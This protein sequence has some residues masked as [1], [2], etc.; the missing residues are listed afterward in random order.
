MRSFEEIRAELEK[1]IGI[2]DPE[3]LLRCA[4]E[5]DAIGTPQ[6]DAEASLARGTAYRLRGDYTEAVNHSYRALALFEE[7]GNST[8]VAAATNN[9]GIVQ[10]HTGNYSAAL[11]HFHRVLALYEKVGSRSGMANATSNIG[12]VYQRTGDYAVALEYFHR[13]LALHEELDNRAGVASAN[14]NI[15]L[16]HYNI[17]DYPAALEHYHLALALREKIGDRDGEAVAISNIG[18]VH[19][20]TGNYPSALE[21]HHRALELYEMIGNRSGVAA[22]INDIGNVH[23]HTGNYSAALE[24]YHRA[25]SIHQET[26]NRANEAI[27][28]GNIGLVHASIGDYPSAI[29]DYRRALDLYEEMGDRAGRARAA[30]SIVGTYLL[31]D[32][33][34]DA[35]AGLAAMDEMQIDEPDVRIVREHIRASILESGDDLN[36]AAATLQR[37][38]TEALEHGLRAEA[39]ESHKRL[40]DLAQKRNDLAG[41]IEHNNEFTR[42]TEEINGK[43]TATKLAMQA[44]QREIEAERRKHEKHLAVLYSTLPKHIADRVARGEVVNDYYENAAVIFLDIVGFTTISDQLASDQVVQLLDR[45]FT[46]LDAVC[47]THGVVKI[48]TIGDSYMAVAFEDVGRAAACALGMMEAL[49]SLAISPLSLAPIRVRIGIHCGPVTAGVIGTQRMQYDVWGDTVNVASRMESTSEPGRI[50]VSEAFANSLGPHAPMP[51]TPRGEIEVKG[52]GLMQTY[53][54]SLT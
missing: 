6:A 32:S 16:V 43:D 26:G 37:A 20:M 24:H 17:G 2:N 35:Q 48:K 15:G 42:I 40:R 47:D 27:V 51:L 30:C 54:L 4:A 25:L 33:N 31:M 3:S 22:A 36:G 49:N 14:N 8:G 9:I 45:I 29:E 11:E 44:K 53:W 12:N 7:L 19:F 34:A 50:Q 10:G 21:H 41:Y 52:K 18:N 13:A 38:L 1:T 5:L 28:I 46:S 23:T 39:A